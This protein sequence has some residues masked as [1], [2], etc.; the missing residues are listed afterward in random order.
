MGL[1]LTLPNPNPNPYPNQVERVE[2]WRKHDAPEPPQ[3]TRVASQ[4]YPVK[5]S[6]RRV[7]PPFMWRGRDLLLA[8]AR[9]E[10]AFAPLP[11][12]TDPLLLHWFSEHRHWWASEAAV[13]EALLQPARQ[14]S[15]LELTRIQH[16]HEVRPLTL[17]LRGRGRGR[18]PHPNPNPNPNPNPTP[19]SKG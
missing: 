19:T 1:G 9:D 8:I 10:L 2:H 16:A 4:L 11:I 17:A 7:P 13:P 12:A 15:L 14:H 5:T 6:L 3:L 18:V